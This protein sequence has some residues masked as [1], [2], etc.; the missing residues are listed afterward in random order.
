MRIPGA[1]QIANARAAAAATAENVGVQDRVESNE[2]GAAITRRLTAVTKGVRA[3]HDRGGYCTD[4]VRHVYQLAYLEPHITISVSNTTELEVVWHIEENYCDDDNL[5]DAG[6]TDGNNCES[7]VHRTEYKCVK[8]NHCHNFDCR[9]LHSVDDLVAKE[10]IEK[11]KTARLTT[12]GHAG[13]PTIRRRDRKRRRKLR[14]KLILRVCKSF[15]DD[16]VNE[17]HGDE[18]VDDDVRK[19]GGA[20]CCVGDDISDNRPTRSMLPP[21]NSDYSS[22][23]SNRSQNICR[24]LTKST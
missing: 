22:A 3:D 9:C 13:R 5:T 20:G 21:G 2:A 14:R 23:P 4:D 7:E 19:K 10:N 1:V 18:V 16:V 24:K 11:R 15:S 8:N 17:D 12:E 6:R